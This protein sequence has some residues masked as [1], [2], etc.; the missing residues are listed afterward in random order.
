M[1]AVILLIFKDS[2]LGL[3]G[4]IQLS[5]NDMVRIGDWISMPTRNA[6]GTVIEVSLNTVKV[7]N[8]DNTISTIPT[9]SLVSETFHNWRGM[10]ESGGRRIKRAINLDMKSVKF[11]SPELLEKLSQF[12]IL[13]DYI[14]EKLKE[15]ENY[16]IQLN[17]DTSVK[18]NGRQLT[19][20]GVF[21]A[22]KSVV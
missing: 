2:I 13:K 22:R 15:I 5:T 20:L 9:Y 10:E 18:A 6:D 14:P 19:N 21:R 8:W 17:I 7:Q 11:C 4:G 1:T 16:N 12:Y 3:V